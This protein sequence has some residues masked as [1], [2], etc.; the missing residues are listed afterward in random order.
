MLAWGSSGIAFQI[1]AGPPATAACE[2]DQQSTVTSTILRAIRNDL[3]I[4]NVRETVFR[5]SQAHHA[6][7]ESGLATLIEQ[8]AINADRP[9]ITFLGDL[10]ARLPV[11]TDA[12]LIVVHGLV[13]GVPEVAAAVAAAAA[14][15]VR[16]HCPSGVEFKQ[17]KERCAAFNQSLPYHRFSDTLVGAA[18]IISAAKRTAS[19]LD[20]F[21]AEAGANPSILARAVEVFKGI[22][23]ELRDYAVFTVGTEAVLLS[24]LDKFQN[25]F[26]Y[27]LAA[28]L[29]RNAAVVRGEA[30]ELRAIQERASMIMQRTTKEASHNKFTPSGV[31][32]G[33]QKV[34]V[35][36]HV[37]NT[38]SRFVASNVST[39]SH[40]FFHASLLLLHPALSFDLVDAETVLFC[41]NISRNPKRLTTDVATS[42][43]ILDF[44]EKW[45]KLLGVAMLKRSLPRDTTTAQLYATVNAAHRRLDIAT[46][47]DEVAG[48]FVNLVQD[49]ESKEPLITP[50]L[51]RSHL[52]I[53]ETL[54]EV[55]AVPGLDDEALQRVFDGKAP[56]ASADSRTPEPEPSMQLD[57][58][59]EVEGATFAPI[60][61]ED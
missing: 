54:V 32:W 50:Q 4:A 20:T 22:C 27:V 44:R 12:G 8:C 5:A 11:S 41:A 15:D 58:D 57:D 21:A 6:A 53:A 23:Q 37:T 45:C 13:F 19:S 47:R 43:K 36:A 48:A 25:H 30:E 31:T 16:G 33:L 28:T 17:W 3:P 1:L 40:P 2:E 38:Q 34:V 56:L 51:T 9:T 60:I 10:L 49:I 18:I 39:L 24:Q 46:L 14:V 55:P 59:V 29:A 42:A 35:P 26:I 61:E 52:L 7:V